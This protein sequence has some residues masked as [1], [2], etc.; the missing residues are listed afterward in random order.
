[1]L[2]DVGFSTFK[3]L[4]HVGR[5]PGTVPVARIGDQTGHAPLQIEIGWHL[6]TAFA[7]GAVTNVGTQAD[8]GVDDQ[9][10]C[11]TCILSRRGSHVTGDQPCFGV[12]NSIELF[13]GRLGIEELHLNGPL[14]WK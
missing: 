1:M 3:P 2:A 4:E 11:M 5:H 6:M 12:A 14:I 9:T 13:E 7:R 10:V 8:I